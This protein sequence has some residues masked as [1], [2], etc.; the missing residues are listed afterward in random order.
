[1]PRAITASKATGIPGR[2][3]LGRGIAWLMCAPITLSWSP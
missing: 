2:T 3:V 1:M